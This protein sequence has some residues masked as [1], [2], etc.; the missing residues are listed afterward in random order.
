MAIFETVGNSEWLPSPLSQGPFD[1]LHGGAL[2]GLMVAEVERVGIDLNIG[3]A[4]SVSVDFFKPTRLSALQTRVEIVRRG[5]RVSVIDNS[6]HQ[7]GARTAAARV[8]FIQPVEINGVAARTEPTLDPA[9]AETLSG[10]TAPHGGS[11]M[12]DNFEVRRS[13]SDGVFWF[14]AL[15]PLLETETPLA[16][17]LA[18]ADWVH[19]LGRPPKPILADPNINLQTVISRPPVGEFIGVRPRTIWTA[20]GVGMGEGE[21]LDC[22]GRFGRVTNSVALT[23]L[24][25]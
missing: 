22:A 7:E 3:M 19:G 12:W 24:P 1:G 4:V 21:L 10:V 8:S 25:A 17:T 20:A 2:A 13:L 6:I 11:W 5:R 16:R 14:R 23:P 15:Q 18:P 9:D